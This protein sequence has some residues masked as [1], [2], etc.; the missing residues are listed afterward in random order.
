MKTVAA[1]AASL[2]LAQAVTLPEL[3][4]R[5]GTCEVQSGVTT[6]FYGFPDNDPPSA[7]TAYSCSG[8][9]GAGGTGTY[10]DPLTFA[11]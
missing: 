7:Q 11:T 1:F 6:T 8:R 5:A 4:R 10:A 2:S 9:D 3:F